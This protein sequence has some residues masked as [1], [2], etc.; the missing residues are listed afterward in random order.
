[1]NLFKTKKILSVLLIFGVVLVFFWQFLLKG[2]IPVPADTIIGLYNPYRDYYAATY[3]RGIPYKNYMITDPVRQQ[4]PW[5][6]LTINLE[7]KLQIPAWNPYTFMGQPLLANIQSGALYPLNIIFFILPFEY[8]W[9]FFILSE[10]L[11][12]AFFMYL[13]LKNLKIHEFA[14][15][16]G[17]ISFAFSGFFISWLEW[18]NVIHTAIW[19]PLVLLSVDKIILNLKFQKSKTVWSLIFLFSIISSFFAGHL[20]VFFYGF[21]LTLLYLIAMIFNLKERKA[22]LITFV[23][24]LFGFVILSLPVWLP[25]LKFILLSARNVDQNFHTIQGWFL[26]WQNLIQFVFPD[27]FGNP[28]TLNYWGIWN[29]GEFIGY[30]GLGGL[31][32]ALLSIFRKDKKTLFFFGILLLSLIFALPTIFAKLPYKFNLPFISTSQPTR[33]IFLAD[34]SLSV[35]AALGLDFIFKIPKKKIIALLIGFS[36]LIIFAWFSVL[37][38]FKANLGSNFIVT[39]QNLIFPTVIFLMNLLLILGFI[40]FKNRKILNILSLLIILVLV[41]DLFRFGWK[42]TPFTNKNYLYPDTKILKYLKQNLGDFRIMTD[43]SRIFPPNFS[44]MYNIQS[45]DGYDP[46]Y[47][48]NYGE[49]AAA[50]ARS[51]PNIDKPFGFNRII[52]PQNY[53]TRLI[54]LFGVKYVLTLDDIEDQHLKKVAQEGETKLYKNINVYPRAFFI[55]SLNSVSNKQEAIN[56]M[57]KNINNLRSQAVILNQPGLKKEWSFVKAQANIRV[58]S[59][60]KIVIDTKNTGDGFLVLTDS[61][62]PNWHAAV[63]G[64]ETK[65]YLTDYNFRG[66]VIPAGKH[67]VE[68]YVTLF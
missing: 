5:K 40:I 45:L 20:Q 57:F 34:F 15:V 8:A 44:V 65:I 59:E 14:A 10:S 17:S 28:A 50:M 39:K 48:E 27:F 47:L 33:L 1:M 24:L 16:F 54:D 58:Y 25:A 26:P 3:P 9:G 21:I 63:D 22:T 4:Y 41:I 30:I 11:L 19:F 13:Y 62:Y 29:Y 32:F 64:K 7:K 35:L 37:V 42:Y 60:N 49:L 38:I 6:Y 2:L 36:L 43:D 53:H 18:G 67:T 66:V 31:F 12:A 46:L 56:F 23:S 61:Y 55:Q 68:F 51:R 52:T